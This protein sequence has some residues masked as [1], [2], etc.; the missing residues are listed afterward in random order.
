[1]EGAQ[2]HIPKFSQP[3]F[4]AFVAG[5]ALWTGLIS[6]LPFVIVAWAANG[7]RTFV[8]GNKQLSF[9]S[10]SDVVS[11]D[12]ANVAVDIAQRLR[13]L[14]PQKHARTHESKSTQLHN[15]RPALPPFLSS[16]AKHT[17]HTKQSLLN[18]YMVKTCRGRHVTPSPI[19]SP[20]AGKRKTRMV[21]S[22]RF[23][24]LWVPITRGGFVKSQ[25]ECHPQ[26]QRLG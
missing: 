25:H 11:T 2:T 5:M 22:T 4:V 12:L 14:P 7:K 21:M 20:T 9:R 1:M 8:A 19:H 3:T 17:T 15:F 24:T 10:H 26:P 6:V 18:N 13:L 23:P 16:I